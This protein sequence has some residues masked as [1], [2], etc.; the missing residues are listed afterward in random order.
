MMQIMT[1]NSGIMPMNPWKELD[2]I[3]GSSFVVSFIAVGE[4]SINTPI[5]QIKSKSIN[6]TNLNKIDG[7]VTIYFW[8]NF[9]P[10]A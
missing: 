4:N 1:K 7:I 9:G 10:H 6:G 3:L 5:L 2:N 8:S